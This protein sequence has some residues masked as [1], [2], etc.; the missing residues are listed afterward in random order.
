MR[1]HWRALDVLIAVIIVIPLA[2]CSS[3]AGRY[4]VDS[5]AMGTMWMLVGI[6]IGGF[7]IYSIIKSV[8]GKK[9]DDKN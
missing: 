3:G 7:V 4:S 9:D 8:F 6:L 1:K 5:G 2:A